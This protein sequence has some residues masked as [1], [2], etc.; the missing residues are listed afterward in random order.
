[1]L[2]RPSAAG[3]PWPRNAVLGTGVG[4]LVAGL[5]ACWAVVPARSA[6]EIRQG[7]PP[8]RVTPPNIVVVMAD[9]MRLRRRALHA[10]PGGKDWSPTKV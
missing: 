3:A 4:A 9:D 7:D 2:R 1:M 10:P 8:L 6:L 5:L